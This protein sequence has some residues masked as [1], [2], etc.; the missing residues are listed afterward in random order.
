MTT[1]RIYTRPY[2]GKDVKTGKLHVFRSDVVPTDETFGRLYSYCIGPFRTMRG[3]KFMAEHG[4]NN[5][6]CQTVSQ[7]ERLAKAGAR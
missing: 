4:S 7:A 1:K 5:P 3:A 6:H 2:V